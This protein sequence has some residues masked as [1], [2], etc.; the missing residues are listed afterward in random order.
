MGP[1]RQRGFV[2]GEID[3]VCAQLESFGLVSRAEHNVNVLA[4]DPVPYALLGKGLDFIGYIK[5]AAE[6]DPGVEAS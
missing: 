4:D 3:S 6:A 5:S 2:Q 1:L